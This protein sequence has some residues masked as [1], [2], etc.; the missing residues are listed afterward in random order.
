MEF[1]FDWLRGLRL[2]LTTLV[3]PN[4]AWQA[5][6][7]ELRFHV[8]ME[9]E[10]L[11][12]EGSSPE[13]ARRE[14]MIRFGG[15]DR[16]AEKTREARGTG[17]G[18]DIMQ[19]LKYGLRMIVKNPVFSA[20]A[21]ITLALGIGANTAIYTVVDAVLLEPLPF[22][23]PD[24]LALLWTRNDAENQD[25]YMVSPMDFDDWRTMNST[26]QSMAAFWPTTGTVTEV[27]GNPTRVRMVYTTEDFFNVMGASPFAGRTF[28]PDEGPGSTPVVVLSHGFWQRRFG[29]D[30]AIVGRAI[31]IDSEPFEVIGIL[32]PEHT[33]PTDADL[34]INMTWGMQI[35]S[36]LARWMSAVGRLADENGLDA[37]RADVAAIAARIEQENPSTNRG[38]T[39]TMEKLR[40]EMVGDTRSAL[41]ILLG[42]TGFILLIACAN[43]ANLLLSRSEVRAKEIAVRVAFGAG[44]G[45]LIRQLITESLVLAGA[46]ALLGLAVAQIGVKVLLG[47]AP[48]T[49]PRSATIGLDGTVLGV[50]A[51]LSLL[52]GALFGLAPIVRLVRSDLHSTMRDGARST[53]TAGKRG[54][55]STFVVAQFALA[56]MLVVGAGL[57]VRS[58]QNLRSV[59]AGFVSAGVLTFE[60]DVSTAIAATHAEVID[61][62][63]QFEQRV[64]ELPGVTAVGD[65][66]TLPLAEAL[67]YSLP[68]SFVDREVPAEVEL[69]AFRRPVSPG[70]LVAMRTPILAG[71]DFN[72]MDRVGAPGVM[73]INEAFVD[74]FFPNEDPIGVKIGDLRTQYGPLGGIHLAGGIT[75]SEIVG[76]VKNVKYD[77]L[78]TDPVPSLYL[79]GL[80]TS[81]KRRT[82]AVR[83]TST[84]ATLLPAIRR[85][86]FAMNP[87][88]A[89][90]NVQTLDA[91]MSNA[92]SRD[93]FSALLLTLFG[94]VALV[95]AS[96]GV[97]GVLAYAVEQ[98]TNEVGIRMALGADRGDVRGMVLIDGFRL[99]LIGLGVG[100][101]G[102]VPL[103]GLLASQLFGVDPREPLIYV[104]VATALLGVGLVA[105][106]VPAWKATR[107]S[108]VVA[109]RCE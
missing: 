23:N 29:G 84:S 1:F 13:H 2:K 34:W 106:F 18:E 71:R 77:G 99:V 17:I 96:V 67:D 65:A 85:E 46:G 35:Q 90:T 14:A 24:E 102:A 68:F 64:A 15:L 7:D 61:F 26:F 56:L 57:L 88:M 74:R 91:V 39:V 103:S 37:A 9:T 28:G 42:A 63:E 38:W 4:A 60:L 73:L 72:S 6:D 41:L 58:F 3:W 105:S 78:R 81:I 101:V 36:R 30:P 53:A 12:R 47:I 107:V 11:M 48:A 44:R 33:F 62:Y 45:R 55:Q 94:I 8:E 100:I 79:S 22:D 66:S 86:L 50:V 108:P 51:G 87:S 54:V 82:V 21:I 93:R 70:F 19:D 27:D 5:L 109:M 32:R 83:S 80:Q 75:A 52:T 104:G 76:V 95:L 31:T 25:R 43:V 40:D 98:R 97:Y 69:R 10:R 16:F 49:L 20:V 59:D 92:Q 89:L